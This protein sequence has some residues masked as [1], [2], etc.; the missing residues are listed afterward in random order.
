MEGSYY[1]LKCFKLL[2][3]HIT[4]P[5]DTRRCFNVVQRCIIIETTSCV[6]IDSLIN[7]YNNTLV[8]KPI[9][10]VSSIKNNTL[11]NIRLC[12]P[13]GTI[14]ILDWFYWGQ[15]GG[16]LFDKKFFLGNAAKYGSVAKKILVSFKPFTSTK[17]VCFQN[18]LRVLSTAEFLL[19]R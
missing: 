10:R 8:A 19:L 14:F 2:I 16:R 1:R 11:N 5:V 7:F 9:S 15:D 17:Y 12:R 6:Y 13:V 18:I 3:G 4:F